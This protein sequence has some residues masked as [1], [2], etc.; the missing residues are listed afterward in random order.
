M[1]KM[2][3]TLITSESKHVGFLGGWRWKSGC[4][5]LLMACACLG[6][7]VRTYFANDR[8]WIS[9]TGT[10]VRVRSMDS[11]IVVEQWHIS[12]DSPWGIQ[13][14]KSTRP[15][16]VT[17][18]FLGEVLFDWEWMGFARGEWSLMS[19]R[20]WTIPY[21]SIVFPLTII[22][23]YVLLNRSRPPNGNE[24]LAYD[25]RLPGRIPLI[26]QQKSDFVR[27]SC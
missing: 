24:P 20:L 15:G 27:P 22:S 21:W 19:V 11:R 8:I 25:C 12:G 1:L 10:G 26:N 3:E 16:K 7:W 2:R 9:P 23:T 5:T 18:L 6:A 13:F 14:S 4:V 17:D